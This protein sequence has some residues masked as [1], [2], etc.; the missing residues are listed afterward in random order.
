VIYKII[1]I[2]AELRAL[3][4]KK[5]KKNAQHYLKQLESYGFPLDVV[6]YS[7]LPAGHFDNVLTA[8]EDEVNLAG[9]S[10]RWCSIQ[11]VMAMSSVYGEPIQTL[12]PDVPYAMRPL[13]QQAI[14]PLPNQAQSTRYANDI[15]HPI[16]IFWSRAG[17]FDAVASLY[18]PNHIV[19]VCSILCAKDAPSVRCAMKVKS[20]RNLGA[21]GDFI[22]SEHR[23]NSH[24]DS[25][26]SQSKRQR[27]INS[28]FSKFHSASGDTRCNKELGELHVGDQ[29]DSDAACVSEMEDDIDTCEI[30]DD[31]EPEGI[32]A[33]SSKHDDVGQQPPSPQ[34]HDIPSSQKEKLQDLQQSGEWF[35]HGLCMTMFK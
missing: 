10:G 23:G 34:A 15:L 29:N 26:S 18:E 32:H 1:S 22:F 35:L 3:C 33:D 31:M 5:L 12:Y 7:I 27:S 11:H 19:P 4:A 24:L 17:T 28:Y 16:T 13:F 21:Q 9:T 20:T 2:T 14:L 6:L 25:Q 8:W 30:E